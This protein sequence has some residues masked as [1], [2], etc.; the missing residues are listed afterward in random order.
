MQINGTGIPRSRVGVRLNQHA[1]F[2]EEL[3]LFQAQ[4]PRS[5]VRVMKMLHS[6]CETANKPKKLAH[7]L[8]PNPI[9]LH[10]RNF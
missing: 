8:T 9:P 1:V 10:L 7:A 2:S 3:G 4:S 5:R 6:V